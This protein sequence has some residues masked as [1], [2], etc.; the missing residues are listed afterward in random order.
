LTELSSA[1][2]REFIAAMQ[3]SYLVIPQNLRHKD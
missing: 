3:K 1:D 2:E